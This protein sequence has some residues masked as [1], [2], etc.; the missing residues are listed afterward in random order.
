MPFVEVAIGVPPQ[1][2]SK[3]SHCAFVPKEP[4]ETVKLT[5]P[6]EHRVSLLMLNDVGSDDGLTI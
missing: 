1:L 2:F 5:F 6:A 3:S 4:P